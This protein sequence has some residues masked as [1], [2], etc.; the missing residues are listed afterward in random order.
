MPNDGIACYDS[1]VTNIK[2]VAKV[3]GNIFGPMLILKL[4]GDN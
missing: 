4:L 3:F 2:E 1:R